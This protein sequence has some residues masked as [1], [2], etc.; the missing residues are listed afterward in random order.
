ML[1]YLVAHSQVI[2]V[3]T[4]ISQQRQG[5][6]QA[7]ACF[8]GNG[9]VVYMLV[10]VTLSFQVAFSRRVRRS[11]I[12]SRIE[13]GDS[14]GLRATFLTHGPQWVPLLCSYIVT[15][16]SFPD[17]TQ[18]IKYNATLYTILV[19]VVVL[20]CLLSDQEIV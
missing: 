5:M 20:L 17:S 1:S 3:A 9:S 13:R 19:V 8:L 6:L 10:P 7:G 12:T 11:G 18:F 16:V 15:P 4:S 2:V 14:F